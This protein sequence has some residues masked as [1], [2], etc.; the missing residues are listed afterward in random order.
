M[1][2]INIIKLFRIL[3][4]LCLLWNFIRN[5][6]QFGLQDI[7]INLL[8]DSHFLLIHDEFLEKHCYYLIHFHSLSYLFL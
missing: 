4:Y 2:I 8:E 6:I 7:I 1:A 3:Y 5:F